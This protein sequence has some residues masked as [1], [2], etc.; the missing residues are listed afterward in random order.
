MSIGLIQY[1]LK[2][3]QE[4]FVWD[5]VGA[6]CYHLIDERWDETW[7]WDFLF[8]SWRSVYYLN[9]FGISWNERCM[10]K[11]FLTGI[12]GC[13]CTSNA[14]SICERW[15]WDFTLILL[16]LP[17][18]LILSYCSSVQAP[19][20]TCLYLHDLA[21]EKKKINLD[22]DDLCSLVLNFSFDSVSPYVLI[23]LL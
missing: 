5:L 16:S 22:W 12:F 8:P 2:N 18:T 14:R 3:I 21:T 10:S 11:S 23:K 1:T 17:F 9:S 4:K 13:W 20:R 7:S 15:I 19:N 6:W